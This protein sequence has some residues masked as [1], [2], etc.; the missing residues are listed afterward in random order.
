MTI[1]DSCKPAPSYSVPT[2]LQGEAR[3]GLRYIRPLLTHRVVLPLLRHHP[4][5]CLQVQVLAH[6]VHPSTHTRQGAEACPILQLSVMELLALQG[7][8]QDAS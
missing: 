2:Y 4:K 1:P 5:P 3:E 7:E 6:E 8:R